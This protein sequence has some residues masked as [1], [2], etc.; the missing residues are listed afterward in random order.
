MVFYKNGSL[1]KCSNVVRKIF[2]N[3]LD[4]FS[5][6]HLRTSQSTRSCHNGTNSDHQGHR[7]NFGQ[8][9]E[10][11]MIE[12]I[13]GL[14]LVVHPVAKKR[15]TPTHH[16]FSHFE[17]PDDELLSLVQEE[18]AQGRV[19][20]GKLPNTFVVYPEQAAARFCAPGEAHLSGPVKPTASRVTVV[21]WAAAAIAADGDRYKVAGRCT[22]AVVSIRAA[23]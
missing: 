4:L 7:L 10:V 15:H 14:R 22:H 5:G 3:N 23:A 18:L 13:S 17:G 8:K 11:N 20:P 6:V 12:G 1:K 19:Q 16:R 2:L 9:Q 21:V